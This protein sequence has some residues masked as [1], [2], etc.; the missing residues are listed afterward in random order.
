MLGRFVI[1][2]A[3]LCILGIPLGAKLVAREEKPPAGARRL[4]V[5]TPHVPQIRSEFS[6][7]FDRWHRRVYDAPVIIDWRSPGAGTTEIL[8]ILSAQY[9]A[10]AKEGKV[11][12]SD[13]KNPAIATGTMAFD[14]MFG[15][16]SFDH[17]RL[18]RGVRVVVPDPASPGA[19]RDLTLP[20]ATPAGF[21]QE[22][23]DAWFGENRIGA[24]R[25][26]DPE[27][28]WIGTAL[29]GFG[30]VY[31]REVFRRL[32]LPEPVGYEDL[33]SPRLAGLLILADPRQSG[34]VTTAIDA[35]LNASLWNMARDE[36]WEAELHA[37]FDKEAKDKT[38]WES[39]LSPERMASVERAF[40]RAWRLLR[41]LSANARA[42]TAAA[43]RPPVDIGAGEGAAGIAID[44]Y[45][46]GQAQAIS[47]ENQDPATARVAYVDPKDAAYIDA[48]PVTIL[49][50]GPDPELAKRFVEFCMSDEGQALWQFHS[51]RHPALSKSNP[52]APDGEPMGPVSYELR[53]MPARRSM[54]EAYLPHMV[55]KVNPFTFASNHRPANWRPAIGL[56][57]GAFSIDVL[58]DQRAAWEALAKAREDR[59]MSPERRAAMERAFYA[60][61][62]T[63]TLESSGEPLLF[64]AASFRKLQ[65]V[66]SNP[67]A[68][69]RLEIAY[70]T[71]FREQ[72]RE[73]VRLAG[74][75]E[76]RVDSSLAS[77]GGTGR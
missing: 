26:Y 5:I 71:F 19:T 59:G 72:Y 58:D 75:G 34:S 60:F 20:M 64:T 3:L 50:G 15:G 45:G 28:Y 67:R 16:G 47:L 46:R 27:Q 24:G 8:K 73:V 42:Y 29:S 13:P 51:Q 41:E 17:G 40:E 35:I 61:P 11:D 65:A 44:F 56:L 2:A 63:P 33:T 53:R 76:L 52:P 9:T 22:Q 36:G 39:S 30:I 18:K 68:M 21:S 38:P 25:L 66:W 37:A 48:D 70:T 69:A 10:V 14:M 7:G 54:Y 55:D 57:M 6:R 49:R 77:R 1:F 4:V 32:G 12:F 62:P 74:G 23:L 43:T 31:N